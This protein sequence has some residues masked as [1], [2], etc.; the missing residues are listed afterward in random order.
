MMAKVLILAAKIVA[1]NDR[2]ISPAI[3]VFICVFRFSNW[4][5]PCGLFSSFKMSFD[6]LQGF[7]LG[8]RQKESCRDEINHRATGEREEHRRVVVFANSRQESGGD[9]RG[10]GL[11]DEED[12]KSVV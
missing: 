11:I 7:P 5:R 12:R 9:G 10:D 2:K 8:F 6:F 1:A 3:F 4:Q